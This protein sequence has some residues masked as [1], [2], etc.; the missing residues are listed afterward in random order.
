MACPDIAF[1]MFTLGHSNVWCGQDAKC[2]PGS[3]LAANKRILDGLHSCSTQ[4]CGTPWD[5]QR[6]AVQ[7]R[8][9]LGGSLLA[10]LRDHQ[11]MRSVWVGREKG[12]SL[13]THFLTPSC[14]R[15]CNAPSHQN[16]CGKTKHG[17]GA[18]HGA[19]HSCLRGI[20]T[21][22]DAAHEAIGTQ[23]ARPSPMGTKGPWCAACQGTQLDE[24]P[25]TSC[26]TANSFSL[27][28]R[29]PVVGSFQTAN[30]FRRCTCF[31]GHRASKKL[32]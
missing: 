32:I 2:L 11:K 21:R 13:G 14:L 8:A 19:V 30:P 31:G 20:G 24:P 29:W 1:I 23:W 26:T 17:E 6:R 12:A 28:P 16:G 4:G 10:G 25:S 5:T 22:T 15:F 9:G 3:W 27:V 7:S 18:F